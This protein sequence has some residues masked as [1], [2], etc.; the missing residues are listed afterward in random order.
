MFKVFMT[1]YWKRFMLGQS[2]IADLQAGQAWSPLVN[3]TAPSLGAAYGES[4]G[5][6]PC[7]L[8]L[9]VLSDGRHMN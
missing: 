9:F 3:C 6:R 7:Y 4:G 8:P 1:V 5:G 2:M